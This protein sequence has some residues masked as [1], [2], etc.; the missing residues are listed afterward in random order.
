MTEKIAAGRKKKKTQ[1]QSSFMYDCLLLPLLVWDRADVIKDM[2]K[3]MQSFHLKRFPLFDMILCGMGE[4]VK[5]RSK[6]K[7]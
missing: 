2:E 1:I 6:E 4:S 3:E 7:K 5:K